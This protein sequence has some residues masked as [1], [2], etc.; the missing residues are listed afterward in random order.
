MTMGREGGLRKLEGGGKVTRKGMCIVVRVC[1]LMS[2]DCNLFR[3]IGC[4]C[5]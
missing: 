2:I 4:S 5:I 1:D 3:G